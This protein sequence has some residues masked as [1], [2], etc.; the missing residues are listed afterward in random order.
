MYVVQ[1]Q[2]RKRVLDNADSTALTQQHEPDHTDYKY[3]C[4]TSYRYVPVVC[5]VYT[6]VAGGWRLMFCNNVM[7]WD[8]R[9]RL[10]VEMKGER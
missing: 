10:R 1:F 7:G 5:G 3:V 2:S 4:P 9:T 6:N 8:H